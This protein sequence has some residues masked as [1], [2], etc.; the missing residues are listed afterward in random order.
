MA[1]RLIPFFILILGLSIA[2][3]SGVR[4]QAS[5]IQQE[6]ATPPV[7]PTFDIARLDP[8]PTAFPSIQVDEGALYFWGVCMGCHGDR[9][10]GLTPEWQD[11]FGEERDCWESG[12]HS[13]DTTSFEL[14]PVNRVPALAGP[15]KLVR[16]SNS[17]ELYTYIL[18]NMPWWN[19]GSVTQEEAWR[20]TAYIMKLNG[21]LPSGLMLEKTNGS[22]IP[23]HRKVTMPGNPLL[24]VLILVSVLM[25][26]GISMNLQAKYKVGAIALRP[27]FVH[28]LHPPTIPLLQSRFRYTLGAGG[29][30]AFLS[31]VLL[32]TGLLEMYYYIPSPESAAVSVET[33]TTL[34]PF[35][36]LVRNLHY[37][38]AQLLVIVM[39]VHLLRVVLTG[40]YAKPRRFNFL[41]G[42][43][44]LVFILLLDFTGYVLRW[45]EGI[46][47]ALVVGTNL[48]K[49][50]PWIGGGLYHFIMGG[51]EPG[52]A[53]LTRFY[54]WHIFGLTLAAIILIG[55]HVFRM[56]R[57]G[58]IAVPPPD[59]RQ[60]K[61]RIS[62]FEL[63]HR[64]VLAMVIVGIVLLLI[65]VFI[66]A[67]IAQPI[68]SASLNTSDS[69]AP[70]FFLWVQ[71]LLKYGDPFLW[72]VFVPLLVVILLGLVP[73]FLPT[74]KAEELGRW[75]PRGNR[76]AQ[77]LVVVIILAILVLTLIGALPSYS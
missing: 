24:G 29:I 63:L 34:V 54:T 58:G 20:V 36:N 62:R 43:A 69:R 32:V 71:Q 67:P 7:T 35:G 18:N 76:L 3:F 6:T 27:N 65:S 19:P 77:V 28:H 1:R 70:W 39:T 15:G 73:Y 26:V 47:W 2:L 48:L 25:L 46:R 68:T 74:A 50:I 8:P 17:F 61:A 4:A 23:V 64:E 11:S 16:F 9:G 75:F 42:L 44:L 10:Q 57:D 22:A 38:S 53:S 41:L 33:I 5:P 30:A 55:W 60:D 14:D 51:P 49:T 13:P 12:C 59:A 45:D 31:L 40:A 52:P 56:R 72:G 21:T 37:W 66:P